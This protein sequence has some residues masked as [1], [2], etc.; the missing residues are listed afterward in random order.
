MAARVS[1]KAK[2]SSSSSVPPPKKPQQ[3]PKSG[4]GKSRSGAPVT[5]TAA[6]FESEVL[7]SKSIW[8]VEVTH[9]HVHVPSCCVLIFGFSS[10]LLGA[11]TARTLSQSGTTPPSSLPVSCLAA[12]MHPSFSNARN[13]TC[14]LLRSS[15]A[16]SFANS[17]VDSFIGDVMLGVVDATIEG[18]LA[19]Q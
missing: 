11:V 8:L 1:G 17:A 2:A 7:Q 18:S 3:Q 9:G 4:G 15:I 6:N 13:L 12:F 14:F 16:G 19:S 5:L 10:W